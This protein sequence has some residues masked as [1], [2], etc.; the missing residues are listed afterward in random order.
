MG[1]EPGIL[2][3]APETLP[4]SYAIKSNSLVLEGV[5]TAF[6]PMLQP[7]LQ[8]QALAGAMGSRYG[9]RNGVKNGKKCA[10][11]KHQD[12]GIKHKA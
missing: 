10:C 6:F 2:V 4:L 1:F 12:Q 3:V 11:I 7:E 8:S 9:V 5:Y